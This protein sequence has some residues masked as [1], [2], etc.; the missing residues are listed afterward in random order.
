MNR[1]QAEK[2]LA[3]LIF[4]DLDDA[5]KAEL[6]A[7]LQTDDEVVTA[8][9]LFKG[10]NDFLTMSAIVQGDIPPPSQHRSDVLVRSRKSS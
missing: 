1:E 5:S 4:D 2:L 7:Y 6:M 9:R 10:D 8:R 3:V